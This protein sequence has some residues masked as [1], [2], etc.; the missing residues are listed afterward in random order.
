M[1]S[2]GGRGRPP[3]DRRR[4][5]LHP[6]VRFGD[7]GGH[8]VLRARGRR[9]RAAAARRRRAHRRERRV[10]HRPDRDRDRHGV[11]AV[12]G[13]VGAGAAVAPPPPDRDG[14]AP[15][16]TTPRARSAPAILDAVVDPSE[17]EASAL[18]AAER[19]AKLPRSAYRGQVRMNRGDGARPPRRR[20]RGRPGP[21]LRRTG[22]TRTAAIRRLPRDRR[23]GGGSVVSVSQL[24]QAFFHGPPATPRERSCRSSSSGCSSWRWPSTCCCGARSSGGC[25]WCARCRASSSRATTCSPPAASTGG[26]RASATTTPISRSRRAP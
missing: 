13:R 5:A 18:E 23:V 10:P 17:L 16:C 14:R 6:A 1:R 2:G 9:G 15:R 3:R 26:S 19:W 20:H 4:R 25:R 8:R 11:P 12:G 24:V 22:L 7:A 21:D